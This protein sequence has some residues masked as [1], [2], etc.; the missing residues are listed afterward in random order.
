MKLTQLDKN[1]LDELQQDISFVKRPWQGLARNL[2][3]TEDKLLNR[4]NSLKKRGVIRRISATFNPKQVGYVST[5]VAAKIGYKD[6]EKVAQRIGSFDE[7]THSYKRD[8]KYN[9]W[10]TLVARSR[11]RITEILKKIEKDKQIKELIELPAKRLFKIKVDFRLSL[12]RGNLSDRIEI[13]SS[14][15]SFAPRN[16]ETRCL[17]TT[18]AMTSRD[19]SIIGLVSQDIPLVKE[20]FGELADKLDIS[21]AT[22][23]DKM[24]LYH[25]NGLMRKFSSVLNH[26]KAGFK[27]NAMVVWNVPP[28]AV[29]K[30]A[31]VMSSFKEVSHCYER[32]K[33]ADWNYNLYS[34][35]HGK[36]KKECLGVVAEISKKTN[37]N[38][39]QALFSTKEYKKTGVKYAV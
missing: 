29:E 34:M 8:Y 7:V 20:P 1:I 11:K 17:S 16:D 38:D 35:V 36:T 23:L 32:K 30:A 5:L 22:L 4:I 21:E 25:K 27:Y 26:H 18:L 37:I 10:F 24:D 2:K 13:A 28:R 19:R 39:Y 9:L 3:I 14:L 15:T 31:N 33:L 6:I 12:R